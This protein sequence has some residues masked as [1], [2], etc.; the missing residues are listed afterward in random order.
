MDFYLLEAC[1]ESQSI[2]FIFFQEPAE[3][4]TKVKHVLWKY[5]SY[6][7]LGLQYVF[8]LFSP[9]LLPDPANYINMCL[10]FSTGLSLDMHVVPTGSEIITIS[11]CK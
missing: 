9:N 10:R 5:L 11:C 1:N 6:I 8:I 7:Q 2:Y 4:S 3:S